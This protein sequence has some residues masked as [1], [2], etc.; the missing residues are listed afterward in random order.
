M[1]CQTE[2]V[3]AAEVQVLT[4]VQ[5]D[6]GALCRFEGQA[7]AVEILLPARRQRRLKAL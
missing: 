1:G 7:T 6:N 4:T 5:A 2:V 3:I